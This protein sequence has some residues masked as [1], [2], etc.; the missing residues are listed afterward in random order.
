[1]RSTV[2]HRLFTVSRILPAGDEVERIFT[3][4]PEVYPLQGRKP[5]DQSDWTRMMERGECFIA[6]KPDEFGAH[7]GDLDLIVSLGLGAVINLPVQHA[8]R[9]L[10]T[11]NLLDAEGAYRGDVVAQCKAM[12]PLAQQAFLEYEQHLAVRPA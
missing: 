6:N 1:M 10:G 9:R 2:G 12:L 11:L 4:M 7:F 5:M 8:G 3:N